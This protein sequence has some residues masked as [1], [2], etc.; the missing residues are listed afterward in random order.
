MWF[1]FWLL[2]REIKRVE[3]KLEPPRPK[4][5]YEMTREEFRAKYNLGDK[6]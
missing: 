2:S 3:K 1:G 6:K 5:D 4:Y